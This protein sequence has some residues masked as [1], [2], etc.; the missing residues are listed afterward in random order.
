MNERMIV[1]ALIPA[2]LSMALIY[3]VRGTWR[4]VHAKRWAWAAVG[5]LTTVTAILGLI[6]LFLAFGALAD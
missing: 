2:A 3:G 6:L 4:D 1:A 5:V